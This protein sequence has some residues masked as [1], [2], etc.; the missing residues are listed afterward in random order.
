MSSDNS[1]TRIRILKATIELLEAPQSKGVRMSDIAKRAGIS[2]QALY[3]HFSTRAELLIETTFYSDEINKS[4]ERLIPSRTAKTGVERL[5]AYVEAWANYIP[6]IYGMGKALMA[7]RDTDEAAAK[8]WDQRMW[9]MKEGCEAA[10]NALARDK[11]LSP[12]YPP[13]HA[14]D[15]LW[16]MLSIRNWEQMTIECGWSQEKYVKTIKSLTKHTFVREGKTE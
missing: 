6:E 14:T 16:A 2:R 4:D 11:T 9:D 1:E 12:L 3:L 7:M 10:I 15:L 8:A 13:A 5:E